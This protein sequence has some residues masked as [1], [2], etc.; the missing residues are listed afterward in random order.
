MQ[1]INV[2]IEAPSPMMNID[3]NKQNAKNNINNSFGIFHK[4]AVL[5]LINKSAA[6]NMNIA[7]HINHHRRIN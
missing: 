4:A 6:N 5:C 3:P 2:K 1:Y 7:E